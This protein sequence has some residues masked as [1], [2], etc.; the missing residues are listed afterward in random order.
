[1]V[2]ETPTGQAPRLHWKH[3]YHARDGARFLNSL[4]SL[5]STDGFMPHGYC[6]TW[7]PGLLWSMVVSEGLVA[8]AY[9]SIP[10]AL[11]FFLRRQPTIRYRGVFLLF[12][13]FIF[14]CA[15]THV[16]GIVNIW[17][18]LY[19]VEVALMVITAAVSI[20][21]ALMLWPLL[22]RA[23]QFLSEQEAMRE[24][25]REAN[26]RLQQ[27]LNEVAERNVALD[28]RRRESEEL[29]RLEVVMQSCLTLGET[30]LPVRST[31]QCL[32]PSASGALYLINASRNYLERVSDWG[33]ASMGG[34]VIGMEDCWALRQGRRAVLH[35]D[36]ENAIRCRHIDP[37]MH[38][39]QSW[40]IPMSAQ[41]ELLGF[42]TLY[43]PDALHRDDACPSGE[44]AEALLN[45]FADRVS[46][47]LAN[48][49]LRETLSRQSVR[50]PLSGLFN[51]RYLEET[52]TRE[53]ARAERDGTS[54]ALLMVDIDHF[55]SFNDQHGHALGDWVIKRV[56]DMLR[57][58]RRGGDVTCRYGGE[59]FVIA[60]FETTAEDA[61]E[62]AEALR[63]AIQTIRLPAPYEGEPG[64]TIS[65]G[66]AAF[67]T[68][69]TTQ[70]ELLAAADGALY[71]A[72][73]SGRNCVVVA[74]T[75]TQEPPETS[76]AATPGAVP[77]L[78]MGQ[79]AG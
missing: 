28:R 60:L 74:T 61:V 19:R 34:G 31:A 78:V 55:K 69:G 20:A 52:L 53:M 43:V 39:G 65:I 46:V 68:H 1:M 14:F 51:R 8:L 66:M 2:V 59:E 57:E 76:P 42:M 13:A 7:Q 79:Q 70:S 44:A 48:I 77:R 58:Q 5:F 30:R 41:G 36:N 18:P 17:V 27:A 32:F 11:L 24:Q 67:P 49:R 3:A 4:T 9:F 38:T 50:D 29:S 63:A 35:L 72:K 62:R 75:P 64:I 33:T 10:I 40:C 71:A 23:S 6:Y 47:N 25:M 56:A 22:P 21:T 54:F 45:E 15:L 73:R 26:L 16:I 37:E 12:S